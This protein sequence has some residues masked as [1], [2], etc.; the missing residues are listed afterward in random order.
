MP[1]PF[2]FTPTPS[3]RTELLNAITTESCETRAL[4]TLVKVFCNLE[5]RDVTSPVPDSSLADAAEG[6]AVLMADLERRVDVT[7]EK[8]ET[9]AGLWPAESGGGER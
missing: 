9:L 8:V 3:E 2:P 7:Q 6:L 4:L 1:K 5:Q